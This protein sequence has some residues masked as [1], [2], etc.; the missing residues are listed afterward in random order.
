MRSHPIPMQLQPH[1]LLYREIQQFRQPWLWFVLLLT[2]GSILYATIQLY[3]SEFFQQQ[4]PVQTFILM[5][6]GL[7]FGIC[8]PLIFYTTKLIVELHTD[9]LVISFFPLLLFVERIPLSSIA[10]Y[11]VCTYHPLKE[12]GGWGIRYGPRGKAYNVNG[13]RGVQI[14]LV[15]GEKILI[16]SQF[17]E[18]LAQALDWPLKSS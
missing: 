17:P 3:F 4:N 18:K 11:E 2:S 12:Y 7:G 6:L 1:Q 8:L 14:M 13:N 9:S 15:S 16:G 5:L 10:D